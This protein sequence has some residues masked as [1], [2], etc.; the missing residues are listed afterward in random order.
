MHVTNTQAPHV[1]HDATSSVKA[2]KSSVHFVFLA[3]FVVTFH[4]KVSRQQIYLLV[5]SASTPEIYENESQ[6]Y[7]LTFI[8]RR[9]S[10]CGHIAAA[11]LKEA[12]LWK[13]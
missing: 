9:A 1:S 6:L 2:K 13:H 5:C 3:D 8:C 7:V 4:I 11:A 10:E 12:G